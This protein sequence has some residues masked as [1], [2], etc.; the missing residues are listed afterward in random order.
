MT[1]GPRATTGRPGSG[2]HSRPA[3]PAMKP[4]PTEVLANS[5]LTDLLLPAPA[6][7]RRRRR[8]MLA[9]LGLLGL[10]G[11]IGAACLGGWLLASA[12][13]P[14]RPA[15]RSAAS[16]SPSVPAPGS[17]APRRAR[18]HRAPRIVVVNGAVLVGLPVN[19]VR[20]QLRHLGLRSRVVMAPSQKRSP[21][22]VLS[23]T[24]TG[25]LKRGTMIVVTASY[26]PR[27]HAHGHRHHHLG[28][29]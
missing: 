9:R 11:I 14:A 23:V 5:A 18:H 22:T 13:D 19:A 27:R 28:G 6:R 1:G 4:A 15:V 25:R 12:S 20:W 2:R 24:P 29:D 7:A 17:T 16:A 10:T 8:P 3:A 26:R 21:G